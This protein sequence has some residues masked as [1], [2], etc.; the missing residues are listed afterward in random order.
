MPGPCVSW[1]TNVATSLAGAATR[2]PKR[3]AIVSGNDRVSYD[4]LAGRAGAIAD[5]VRC[6]AEPGDRVAILLPG[7]AEAA[8]AFF[9]VLAAGTV[10]VNVND[11]LRERQIGHILR[12]SGAKLVLTSARLAVRI[13]SDAASPI[14][15]LLTERLTAGRPL[16]PAPRIASDVAHI[17]YTSGSTG[18]PKG[19]VI[20]H[21]NLWSGTASVVEYLRLH[22]EDQIAGLLPF[23]F[24]YGLNQ[25]LCAVSTAATLVIDRSPIAARVVETLRRTQVSVVPAIPP[26]W[27][28]LLDVTA[29]RSSIPSIRLLTNT[30][31]RLP[32]EAVRALRRC[33]PQAE[34]VLMYGLTE[35][36]RSTYL[37]PAFADDKPTSIGRAIPGA[38]IMVLNEHGDVC[39]P[40][41]VG[42]I[43]HRGPTVAL[44][45]WD[46]EEATAARFRPNPRRSAGTPIA[47]RVVFSGDLGY[48]DDG[49]DLYFVGRR[50]NLIKTQGY[51]VSP[52]EVAEALYASGEVIEAV[53]A[54]EDDDARGSRIVAYIVLSAAGDIDR[55]TA[56]SRREL[57]SYMQ[58]ARYEVSA[59]LP[60]T[61]SGKFDVRVAAAAG[62]GEPM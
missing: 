20:S 42:E 29:F 31:G 48:R 7:R 36:F 61:S 12:H 28:Q 44:G 50:D 26:L 40:G 54:S 43:V 35:A 34:L 46:D 1:S 56:Y 51:R 19:V 17:I 53:V 6:H 32:S 5:V 8:A 3:T 25:L 13:P 30:G 33:Q 55:L 60:R 57:P 41:E 18:L 27:L 37:N 9:G 22:G 38:E 45:Y 58:P 21:G 15:I 16:D 47:E 52:D 10:A 4:E 62:A 11:G 24:D 49:G 2:S 59:A 39:A 14:P 23:S